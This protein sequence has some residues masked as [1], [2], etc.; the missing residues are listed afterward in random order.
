MGQAP[1]V[2]TASRVSYHRHPRMTN[3]SRGTSC[4]Y[5]TFIFKQDLRRKKVWRRPGDRR[6]AFQ[7]LTVLLQCQGKLQPGSPKLSCVPSTSFCAQPHKTEASTV[8]PKQQVK[9]MSSWH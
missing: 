6:V 5:L 7:L 8:C 3:P 1:R 4:N 9:G 2:S